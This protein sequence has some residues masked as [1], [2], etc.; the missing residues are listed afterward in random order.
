MM[1]GWIVYVAVVRSYEYVLRS[2]ASWIRSNVDTGEIKVAQGT[3]LDRSEHALVRRC[4][5]LMGSK[6]LI[7]TTR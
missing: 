1:V 4:R 3:R 5:R 7:S 6:W 2:M